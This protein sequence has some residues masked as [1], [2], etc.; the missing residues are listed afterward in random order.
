MHIPN[1][2]SRHWRVVRGLS[3]IMERPGC[4]YKLVPVTAS[5]GPPPPHAS[6]HVERAAVPD[7]AEV[8]VRSF[9]LRASLAGPWCP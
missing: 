4:A 2:R 1:G 8:G 7:E 9:L 3:R 5:L 6:T